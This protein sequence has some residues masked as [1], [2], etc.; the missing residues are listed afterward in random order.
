VSRLEAIWIKRAHRRP[1]EAVDSARMV[2]GHGL[3][4][5]VPNGSFR[6]VTLIEKEVWENLMAQVH[7]DASP[8]RRRANLMVSGGVG[9]A[10]SRGRILKIGSVRL[11][12]AGETKPC[13]QM[14]Q[15]TA[16]LQQAMS[17]NWGGG[18]YARV[19]DEGTIAVGDPVEWES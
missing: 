14:E 16:G 4:G 9:L 13:E 15:V 2:P 18:A 19:L 3:E 8:A 12:I 10:R 11:E 1:T 6:Q 17:L 7:A 5:N